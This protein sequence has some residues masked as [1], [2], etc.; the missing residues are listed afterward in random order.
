MAKK[1][2]RKKSAPAKSASAAKPFQTHHLRTI[3]FSVG[4]LLV[5]WYMYTS[6]QQLSTGRAVWLFIFGAL[7]GLIDVPRKEQNSFIIASLG[8]MLATA[9]PFQNIT[10]M[11]LG[12]YI[13]SF[14]MNLALFVTPAVVIVALKVI[15]RLFQESRE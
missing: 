10:Y 7:V 13:K 4:L 11:S 2:K 12:L 8:L 9:V 14:L 3:V 1:R 5:A 6:P 15:Y